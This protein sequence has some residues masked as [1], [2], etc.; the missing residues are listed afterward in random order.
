MSGVGLLGLALPSALTI[1]VD[2]KSGLLNL[3]YRSLLRKTD[4]KIP[5]REIESIDIED[6]RVLITERGGRTTPLRSYHE[7]KARVKHGRLAK[8]LRELIGVG[9]SDGPTLRT[10]TGQ[11]ERVNRQIRRQ[12]ETLTGPNAEM[13]ESEGVRWNVQSAGMGK[14]PVTR[15]FSPDYKTDG[16]FV[17]VAQIPAREPT[18][19]GMIGTRFTRGWIG[20]LAARASMALYGF[21][22]DDVQSSQSAQVLALDPPLNRDFMAFS[23]DEVVARQLLNPQVVGALADWAARHPLKV[24]RVGNGT[25]QLAVLFSPSGVYAATIGLMD[26]TK[27]AELAA[28][29][30]ELVKH[31]RQNAS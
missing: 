24:V 10:L 12:Q 31:L 17:Y 22:G 27:L 1:R 8:R 6:H 21:V 18:V 2:R 26:P 13:R 14:V 7:T 5:L 11:D 23:P 15:W 20:K 19:G 28:I 4:K 30:K 25:G 3:N 16:P 29:G 9:G